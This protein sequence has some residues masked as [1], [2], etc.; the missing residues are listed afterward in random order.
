M[1]LTLP[2]LIGF[3]VERSDFRDPPHTAWPVDAPFRAFFGRLNPGV[4]FSHPCFTM[5]LSDAGYTETENEDR[6]MRLIKEQFRSLRPVVN[7]SD[8]TRLKFLMTEADYAL[9]K[10]FFGGKAWTT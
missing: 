10:L 9:M 7:S 3:V 2:D 8:S 5:L 6:A 1:D 4:P